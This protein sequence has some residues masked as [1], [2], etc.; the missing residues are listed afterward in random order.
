MSKILVTG[1]SG[2]LGKRLCELWEGDDIV[3]VDVSGDADYHI[4]LTNF[5]E[6]TDVLDAHKPRLVIHLAA[7]SVVIRPDNHISINACEMLGE[8]IWSIYN[9]LRAINYANWDCR[10]IV[11]GSA[12]EYGSWPIDMD[13]PDELEGL[14]PEE[15][16]GI[17]KSIGSALAVH[18][19]FARV[20]RFSNLYGPGQ[21]DKFIPMLIETALAGRKLT[22]HGKGR[23]TRQFLYVDD[24]INA[25]KIVGSMDLMALEDVYNITSPE[26]L[27]MREVTVMVYSAL[28]DAM[29][30]RGWFLPLLDLKLEEEGGGAQRVCMNP[31]MAMS[32]LW[33]K[34][35]V[36]FE[37]GIKRTVNTA[38]EQKYVNKTISDNTRCIGVRTSDLS[39]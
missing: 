32:H 25:I 13:Q 21:R 16:Y 37:E 11:A 17:S 22:L 5:K 33:W 39:G 23:Q 31:E 29:L 26:E 10:L 6:L 38:L 19:P 7:R 36:T 2:F 12:S 14:S 20:L 18:M 4:N 9:I 8:N 30:K 27:S 34:P 35:E 15:P 3:K 1:S 24:A 28:Q